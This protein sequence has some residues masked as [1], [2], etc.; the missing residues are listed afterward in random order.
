MEE[1]EK[2]RDEIIRQECGLTKTG[3]C[4][5]DGDREWIGTQK[6][7]TDYENILQGEDLSANLK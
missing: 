6:Q 5:E 1:T 3:T 7:W 4:N 2:E